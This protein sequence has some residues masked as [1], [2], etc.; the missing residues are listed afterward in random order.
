MKIQKS[1]TDD[2]QVKITAEFDAETMEQFK[3]R[4][5]R[6][7]SERTRIPGFRPGKAPYA[8]VLR[9]VGDAQVSSQ[10]I[11]MLV[12]DSYP[13]ILDEE[14]IKPYGPGNLDK[15]VS[16]NPPVFEFSIPLDP[17]VELNKAEELKSTYSPEAVTDEEVSQFITSTRRNA[18][19]IVPLETP[20]AE[21]N[22]VYM[23]LE[24][25]DS[26]A[27]GT[28]AQLIKATPNQVLIP[29][30]KEQ[31]K[32]EWPFEG[33][34]RSLISHKAGETLEFEHS[35]AEDYSD[36]DLAGKKVHFT[37]KI[38]SVKG[39]ELP[40]MNEEY[41]QSLGGFKT[42]EELEKAVRSRLEAEKTEAYDDKYYLDLVDQLRKTA[43][44]KY[45]PQMLANEEEQVLHRIEHDLSH[46]HMDLDLYL[47][48]R[49][50]DK[51][52]FIKEEV[53]PTA[54]TRLERSLVMD[55]LTKKYELKVENKDVEAQ[56]NKLVNNLIMSGEFAEMQKEFGQKKFAESITMD[57]ANRAM[58]AKIRKQ[59]L[60][61]ADPS[62]VKTEEAKTEEA[63]AE[64]PAS[65]AKKAK[66]P[67]AEAISAEKEIS[68]PK[69]PEAEAK[70]G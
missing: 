2:H 51:E 43:V 24:A 59:L 50:T 47:K 14:K 1:Y 69:A 67:K 20:A 27:E 48:I 54:L 39:L 55:A 10:A 42:V 40:E 11:E 22:V 29:S 62:A 28:E 3:H 58:E 19:T 30:K 26:K 64:K 65:K 15:I 31:P 68:E 37:V 5:A 25:I 13:K 56:V 45:P 41:L 9:H 23:S 70:E 21:G 44:L 66:A 6:K 60:K 34:A 7:I 57:A 38:E 12:D 16:E 18:A 61:M 32:T 49:K 46:R 52:S 17:E 53:K 35:F 33:F 36:K 8:M 4:A 63:Q